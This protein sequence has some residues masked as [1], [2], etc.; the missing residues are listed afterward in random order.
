MFRAKKSLSQNFLH[1]V[2]V[3]RKIVE[4]SKNNSKIIFEIGAG[5]GNLTDV[6]LA[7]LQDHQKLIAIEVDTDLV[8]QLQT[9][10]DQCI[11]VGK[12]EMIHTDFK[13][14]NFGQ[15][16]GDYSIIANVPYHLTKLIIRDIFSADNLP[17]SIYFVIQDDVAERIVERDGKGSLLSKSVLVYAD[18]KILYNISRGAFSPAPNVDSALLGLTNISRDKM[19]ADNEVYFYVLRAGFAH[20]RKKLLQNLSHIL[21]KEKLH[22]YFEK[23]NLS[24]DIR[25]EELSTEQWLGLVHLLET[26]ILHNNDGLTQE[27]IY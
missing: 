10:F 6:I 22:K 15:L 16:G 13:T 27:T 11:R 18:A 5:T 21:N 4:L 3:I 23:L 14:F 9:R 25:A 7:Q 20:K 1:D 24:I 17:N 19:T 12:L 26:D 8:N 2:R